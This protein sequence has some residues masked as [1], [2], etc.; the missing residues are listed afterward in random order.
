MKLCAAAGA[1]QYAAVIPEN[2]IVIVIAGPGG[3]G[4]AAIE[5]AASVYKAKVIAVCDTEDS[6]VVIRE[7]GAFQTIS[8]SEG[9]QKV[10]KFLRNALGENRAAV[11]YDAVGQGHLHLL[12]DL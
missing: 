1:N 3:L 5:V 12:Q 4:L 2:D 10:Y 7:E 9:I 8:M 11:I 6:S